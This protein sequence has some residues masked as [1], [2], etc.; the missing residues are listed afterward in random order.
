MLQRPEQRH[1]QQQRDKT[2]NRQPQPYAQEIVEAVA[3]RPHH[4]HIHWVRDRR[5]KRGRAAD[6]HGYANCAGVHAQLHRGADGDRPDD[7]RR[8]LPAYELLSQRS[9]RW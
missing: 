6:R 4:Q 1:G 9:R 7:Q 3:A 2:N 5:Q 8:D